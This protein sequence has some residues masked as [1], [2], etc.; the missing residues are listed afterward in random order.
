MTAICTIVSANYINYAEV[1]AES[2]RDYHPEIIFYVLVVD[3]ENVSTQEENGFTAITCE[4]IGVSNLTRRRFKYN[5]TEFCTSV[6]ATFIKHLILQGNDKVIY[7][8]P[9]ILVT[10]RMVGLMDELRDHDILLTPHLDCPTP[11][12][13]KGPDY[14]SMMLTGAYNLGFIALRKSDNSSAFLNWWERQ[15]EVRCCDEQDVGLFTDQ[16]FLDIAVTIFR[17][18]KILKN[19]GYNV[20]PW[21]IYSR[22]LSKN[23]SEW[24]CNGMPL[25]FYHFSNYGTRLPYQIASYVSRDDLNSRPDLKLIYDLYAQK[26][27]NHKVKQ[28]GY[29]FDFFY[30]GTR[31]SQSIRKYYRSNI[32]IFWNTPEPFDSIL[33]RVIQEKHE[34]GYVM[35]TLIILKSIPKALFKFTEKVR[36]FVKRKSN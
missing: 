17:G 11:E 15:L 13:G 14:I 3:A 23:E 26:L 33:L 16:K 34:Y 7:L 20:A 21:N 6:K 10:R 30:D 19:P 27:R 24:F 1:L 22:R 35:A 2:L 29:R 5:V 8:D 28:L 18:F 31:I 32:D 36:L 25:Y 4:Q 12:D 9:D